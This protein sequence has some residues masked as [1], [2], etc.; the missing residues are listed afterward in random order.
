MIINKNIPFS[1]LFH[2]SGHNCPD[3]VLLRSK[4]KPLRKIACSE[5]EKP[6]LRVSCAFFNAGYRISNAHPLR[7]P[8]S[9]HYRISNQAQGYSHNAHASEM[10]ISTDG[11]TQD[12]CKSK[13]GYQFLYGK[14]FIWTG[15]RFR[16]RDH[17]PERG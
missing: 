13:A 10:T 9:R 16:N 3:G 4:N 12:R 11:W 15:R 6:Q 17:R 2:R 7:G 1:M 8:R 14:L 5:P